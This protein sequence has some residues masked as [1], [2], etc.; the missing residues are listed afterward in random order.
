MSAKDLELEAGEETHILIDPIPSYLQSGD[1]PPVDFNDIPAF[2]IK[3]E[4]IDGKKVILLPPALLASLNE[5]HLEA[6]IATLKTSTDPSE[7]SRAFR[8]LICALTYFW[9]STMTLLHL[10]SL[11]NFNQKVRELHALLPPEFADYIQLPEITYPEHGQ[12]AKRPRWISEKNSPPT[13]EDPASI[14]EDASVVSAAVQDL[15]NK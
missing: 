13:T 7:Q 4:V 2:G 14:V 8:N 1:R 10:S 5:R 6:W 3:V 12:G 9:N 11:E 15:L